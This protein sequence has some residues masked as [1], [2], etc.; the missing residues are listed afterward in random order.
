[1]TGGFPK[2]TNEAM[3]V[4]LE[5][6]KTALAEAQ[7]YLTLSHKRMVT[8]VTHS[9]Q[10]VEFNVGDEV[11][12]TT[13]HINNYCPQLPA[14]IKARWAGPFTITQKVSLVAYRVDLPPDWHLH[15][16]F[17]IDKLNKYICSEEFLREVHP[18]PPIVVEDYL[19]YEVEDLIRHWGK[20]TRR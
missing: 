16:V 14:K 19:E 6:M 1:M 3:Y 9:H 17:H 5:R 18:P 12:L 10:S 7:T 20:G 4:T 8:A 11:V 15:P 13:K 2:T